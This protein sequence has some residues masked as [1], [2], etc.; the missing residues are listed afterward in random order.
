MESFYV[1]Y[2]KRM[3]TALVR[4]LRVRIMVFL[5]FS[6]ALAWLLVIA[7][8]PFADSHFEFGT[9]KEFSGDYRRR[10]LSSTPFIHVYG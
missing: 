10:A 4:F 5:L 2:Q 1:G 8:R 7:R 3:P 6:M 9:V